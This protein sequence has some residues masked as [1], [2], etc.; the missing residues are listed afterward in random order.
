MRASAISPRLLA[1]SVEVNEPVVV[2]AVGSL[3]VIGVGAERL[4]VRLDQEAGTV[5]RD[6]PLQV[7]GCSLPYGSPSRKVHLSLNK[8][9][10]GG[11][12][13]SSLFITS[14]IIRAP[15]VEERPGK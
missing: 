7:G 10:K 14:Y 8:K 1:H 12:L 5:P 9:E 2:K 6:R 13:L 11:P 3:Q 4:L 15:L